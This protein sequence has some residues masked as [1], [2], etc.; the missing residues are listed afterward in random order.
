MS[1]YPTIRIRPGYVALVVTDEHGQGRAIPLPI[2]AANL[3]IQDLAPGLPGNPT[4]GWVTMTIHARLDIDTG[5]E[6][7]AKE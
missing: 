5:S 2:Q 6:S 7:E 3:S 1:D 4:F